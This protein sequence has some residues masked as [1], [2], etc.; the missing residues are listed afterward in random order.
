[1]TTM[2]Q[3]ARMPASIRNCNPG[4]IYPGPS[5]KRFGGVSREKLVSGD[6]VHQIAT[7]PDM[8]SGAAALFDNLCHAGPRRG[9]TY[10]REQRL[11]DAIDTWCGS[12]RTP[13]YLR[14]INEH[15]GIDADTVLTLGFLRDPTSAIPLAMAM[16]RQET[17]RAYPLGIN[18]WRAAHNR[19]L[20]YMP[21]PEPEAFAAPDPDAEHHEAVPVE[22]HEAA[23]DDDQRSWT[24]DNDLPS[25]RVETR[26]A[27]ETKG[28]RKWSLMARARE[29][30]AA[31]G[32]GTTGL[33]VADAMDAAP[34]ALASIKS[35]AVDN[36][37]LLLIALTLVAL[38]AV[39][40]FRVLM[41]DD[42][43]AGRYRSSRG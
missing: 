28:S 19:A 32:I 20:D 40:V 2:A 23:D 38:L 17:G 42:I 14:V 1:M 18:E 30:L 6:G 33:G 27:T 31:L 8:V 39:E 12:H 13:S 43:A 9:V 3:P 11:A 34:S 24:P 36:W 16:A 7:F 37:L 26:V 4:C 21:E 22:D 10:Y 5:A 25:P 41:R 15:A 35:F 29:F